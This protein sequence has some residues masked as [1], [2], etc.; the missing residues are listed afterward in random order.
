MLEVSEL[1]RS[2]RKKELSD[3]KL[4]KITIEYLTRLIPPSEDFFFRLFRFF[5]YPLGRIPIFIHLPIKLM[6]IS[7][8]QVLLSRGIIRADPDLHAANDDFN[9]LVSLTGIPVVFFNKFVDIIT[10]PWA[11]NLNVD[12]GFRPFFL[13]FRCK[14]S[15]TLR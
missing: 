12:D 10:N 8:D 1:L 5:L 6:M 3:Q 11:K 2:R 15:L 7:P 9:L 14:C 4:N 13:S